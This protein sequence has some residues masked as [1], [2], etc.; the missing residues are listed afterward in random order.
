MGNEDDGENEM[1]DQQM[2]KKHESETNF[3]NINKMT[4][5]THTHPDAQTHAPRHIHAH[6]PTSA[7]H[8]HQHWETHFPQQLFQVPVEAHA[9]HP[10][11]QAGQLL[12]PPQQRVLGILADRPTKHQ[13]DLVALGEPGHEAGTE[14][15]HQVTQ[16]A[17]H[18]PGQ[19]PVPGLGEIFRDSDQR[20]EH[21]G[22]EHRK[23][24]Q[25]E[26]CQARNQRYGVSGSK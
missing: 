18:G 13:R 9:A 22:I 1:D 26:K 23:E 2:T 4:K 11:H 8:E 15:A 17:H 16:G 7:A 25:G 14:F 24:R 20:K 5:N 10:R 6:T 12:S 3:K 21:P 19:I